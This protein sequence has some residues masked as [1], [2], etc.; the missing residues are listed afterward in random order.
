[1]GDWKEW[2]RWLEEGMNVSYYREGTKY[3]ESIIL[4][5]LAHWEY[6]WPE[7]ISAG[8][9]SGPFVPDDLEITR[10]YEESTNLNHLWQLI[11]GLKGQAYIYIELPTDTHR[12]GIPKQPKP[13]STLR[14]VSH[15]EEYMSPYFEPSF[16]TE[17][18]LIRPTNNQIAF[19]AYNPNTI[20][21]VHEK[22]TGVWLNIFLA[23]LITERLGTEAVDETG[24]VRLKPARKRWTEK[25]EN[26][27]Y[28]KIPCRP[29]TLLPVREPAEAPA[30]E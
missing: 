17:H 26:L 2:S 14:K 4:R 16:I 28:A 7:T 15:F 10:G 9:E 13:S 18:I 6:E 27:Y 8:H 24:V 25:L 30:G 11:F 12:H 21:L 19:S 20:D 22:P 3:Y 1:M 29:L 5:D 23:K